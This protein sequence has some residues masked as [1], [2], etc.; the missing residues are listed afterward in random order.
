M[1]EY[2]SFVVVFYDKIKIFGIVELFDFFISYIFIFF[3]KLINLVI[4]NC[5]I[6]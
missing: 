5:V 4:L 1:S 2:I 6:C 3:Y